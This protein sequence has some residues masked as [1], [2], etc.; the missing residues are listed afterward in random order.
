MI[1]PQYAGINGAMP[2]TLPPSE[3]AA[4]ALTGHRTSGNGSAR[5]WCSDVRNTYSC[6][7]VIVPSAPLTMLL[8]TVECRQVGQ[9][10][11]V[12]RAEDAE[13]APVAG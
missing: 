12:D 8:R 7:N 11:A 4:S 1:K 9:M 5:C 10:A 3:K 6:E 13:T 2:A